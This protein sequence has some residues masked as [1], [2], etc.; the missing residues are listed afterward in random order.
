MK[1]FAWDTFFTQIGID[2]MGVSDFAWRNAL[3]SPDF[4]VAKV[5]FHVAYS[6]AKKFQTGNYA[7][8][9]K[10]I[11]ALGLK[12]GVSSVYF[13]SQKKEL[14]EQMEGIGAR[15]FRNGNENQYIRTIAYYSGA[16]LLKVM[17]Q[18]S[19]ELKKRHIGITDYALQ[20]HTPEEVKNELW[21]LVESASDHCLR[22]GDFPTVYEKDAVL[23]DILQTLV[24]LVDL[25]HERLANFSEDDLLEVCRLPIPRPAAER[26]AE[27]FGQV[28]RERIQIGIGRD[29]H[30]VFK[31]LVESPVLS[32]DET[33]EH[34]P[35]DSLWIRITRMFN[36][37]SLEEWLTYKREGTSALWVLDYSGSF[38]IRDGYVEVPILDVA[39]ISRIPV[40]GGEKVAQ[41]TMDIRPRVCDEAYI[42]LVE[43]ADRQTVYLPGRRL[44]SNDVCHV[45]VN[46]SSR[47]PS[48]AIRF[49]DGEL[50]RI[51]GS[52]ISRIPLEG[53]D[54]EALVIDDD[55]FPI[56]ASSYNDW[57]N[58]EER[59]KYLHQAGCRAYSADVCP[60]AL[61][62]LP[63]AESISYSIADSS[64]VLRK[65]AGGCW[66]SWRIVPPEFL[67]Q[68]GILE[69]RGT[70]GVLKSAKV[71]FTN[72]DFGDFNEP[73][74]VDDELDPTTVSYVDCLGSDIRPE[75]EYAH[76]DSSIQFVVNGLTVRR[77]IDR[78]G[79][80][81]ITPAGRQ[82][83]ISRESE[84]K[85]GG[86]RM[87]LDD[88]LNLTCKVV[89]P[90]DDG[91]EYHILLTRGNECVE[92]NNLAQER[93]RENGYT[94]FHWRDYAKKFSEQNKDSR[95][96]SI[97]IR[98]ES[99]DDEQLLWIYK[100][101]G[102]DPQK[103]A[104]EEKQGLPRHTVRH[105]LH[106]DGML[107][108]CHHIA[109]WD[110]AGECK[111]DGVP[112][113]FICCPV[114]RLDD[115]NGFVELPCQCE[116]HEGKNDSLA[117]EV[118]AVPGFKKAMGTRLGNG[119]VCFL[120]K[121]LHYSNAE[122]FE[123]RLI[124]SGFF[125][126]DVTMEAAPSGT[127]VLSRL[128]HAISIKDEDEIKSILSSEDE[129]TRGVV[130]GVLDRVWRNVAHIHAP[131]VRDYL[132]LYRCVITGKDG[133]QVE[134]SGYA[135]LADWYDFGQGVNAA[136]GEVRHLSVAYRRYWPVLMFPLK[137][138]ACPCGEMRIK[139]YVDGYLNSS[140]LT[141]Q[142]KALN[143]IELPL[144]LS[145][146]DVLDRRYSLENRPNHRFREFTCSRVVGRCYFAQYFEYQYF[147][148]D[149]YDAEKSW[150]KD[151]G[152]IQ[153]SPRQ[154]RWY[155]RESPYLFYEGMD[156]FPADQRENCTRP[157][158]IGLR[159]SE[160]RDY[161]MDL[162]IELAAWR[163]SPSLNDAA[164]RL[165]SE[166]LLLEEIDD[167]LF[168]YP[169]DAPKLDA[170]APCCFTELVELLA[171]RQSVYGDL[172]QLKQSFHEK[173]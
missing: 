44:S 45:L 49:E 141:E 90:H 130:R 89:I 121:K 84:D 134:R 67:W 37:T 8:S 41:G 43:H 60:V 171:L 173:Q 80:F 21:A 102:V 108:I 9:W 165:K 46:S 154:V 137:E 75:V 97:C 61:E 128:R 118:V 156:L 55:E 3:K 14:R 17:Q 12:T 152:R 78:V 15:L 13:S 140:I 109:Y 88:I 163:R 25:Y 164:Q 35:Y 100:F 66:A 127:D 170:N 30:G 157:V 132:N 73:S 146:Y 4:H 149:N 147:K 133:K 158:Q 5:L 48:V 113:S 32:S 98:K 106:E 105:V 64:I 160:I 53:D 110:M 153:V 91:E 62:K 94:T 51:D 112:T 166:L 87:T 47:I 71:I 42:L 34:V 19:E 70:E 26:I 144:F 86:M 33:K 120:T 1:V 77:P 57:Q 125:V 119:C 117:Q 7:V 79:V 2:P 145:F 39:A 138:L 56:A 54:L 168:V 136:H 96:F 107:K 150:E 69:V 18:I 135:F 27:L 142:C 6:V 16:A 22:G 40:L 95:H 68:R 172:L 29:G 103:I 126:R 99:D 10:E 148:K 76:G 63:A 52:G 104:Y 72:V 162:A 167:V 59:F 161:L 11:D 85:R 20:Y 31:F 92:L 82:I 28:T 122:G 139:A 36:G 143:E 124:A 116:Y 23:Q 83:S 50:R 155:N 93:I 74:Q 58:V 159:K 24:S 131:G 81:F 129:M 123:H 151:R 38:S 65:K 101:Y 111:R 169:P 115:E 114:D